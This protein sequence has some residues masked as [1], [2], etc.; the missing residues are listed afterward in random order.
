MNLAFN[1]M[2]IF[3][4]TFLFCV[5]IFSDFMNFALCVGFE[6]AFVGRLIRKNVAFWRGEKFICNFLH[7][8]RD[9]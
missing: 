7:N 2:A 5:C 1:F 4:D 9:F 6:V 8:L 3:A